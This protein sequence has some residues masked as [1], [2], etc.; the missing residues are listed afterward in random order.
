MRVIAGKLRGRT[1]HA[2]RGERTRPTHGRVREALFSVLGDVSG[3]G[4]AD[5]CAGTGALGIEALSRGARHACFVERS[6]VALECL[7]RNVQELDLVEASTVIARSVESSD[8]ELLRLG[9]HDLVFCD[10]PWSKIEA[11]VAVLGRL[12]PQRWLATGGILVLEHPAKCDPARLGVLGLLATDRR[13]W[14]DTGATFFVAAPL[15]EF[16]NGSNRS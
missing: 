9:P 10:P 12:S 5:L 1:L 8:P 3:M 2:P 11:F 15:A 14:G 6:R 4:V 16:T 13:R 7:R